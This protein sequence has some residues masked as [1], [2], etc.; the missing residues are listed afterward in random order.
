MR[1]VGGQTLG[2]LRLSM[3]KVQVLI[4]PSSARDAEVKIF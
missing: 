3:S 1:H 4:A 2:W